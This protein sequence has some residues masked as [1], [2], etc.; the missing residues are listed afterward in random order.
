MSS[1]MNGSKEDST[2]INPYSPSIEEYRALRSE[3]LQRISF[4][5]TQTTSVITMTITM[6]VAGFTLL[7]IRLGKLETLSIYENL[8]LCIGE[9]LAFFVVLPI[10]SSMSIKC[11]ENVRQIAAIGAYIRVFFEYIPLIRKNGQ[12]RF[13]W[14][15][16]D[17]NL[18]DIKLTGDKKVKHLQRYNR[19]YFWIAIASAVFCFISVI[20]YGLTAYSYFDKPGVV[21]F[22][23]VMIVECI[24]IVTVGIKSISTINRETSVDKSFSQYIRRATNLYLDEAEKNEL[25]SND[26]KKTAIKELITE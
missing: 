7:G 12:E 14:E 18:S 3:A 10:I 13:G 21:F 9:A 20:S 15:T 11:G 19:E 6:W 25:I 23:I 5:N 17:I 22:S 26:E 24:F 1:K 8:G 2:L 4:V 16:M